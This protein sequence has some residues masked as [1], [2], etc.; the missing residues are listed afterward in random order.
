ML[1]LWRRIMNMDNKIPAN[2]TIADCRNS[3]V[4]KGKLSAANIEDKEIILSARK[5]A[6][7]TNAVKPKTIFNPGIL[8][9]RPKSTPKVVATPL[10]P[11]NFK[12]IVQLCPHIQLN[13]MIINR[14]CA[15]V[16]LNCF[17]KKSPRRITGRKP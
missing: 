8:R 2:T 17:T 5:L 10:P 1:D 6:N 12:N 11:L 15:C 9:V 16:K 4:N 14:F 3:I 7:Q 13:P